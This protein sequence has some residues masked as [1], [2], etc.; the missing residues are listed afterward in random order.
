MFFFC[1]V[2]NFNIMNTLTPFVHA[3][4][5]VISTVHWTPTWTNGIF[6][7]HMWPFF[8]ICTES[9]SGEI[10]GRAQSLAHNGYPSIWWP[11]QI[12]SLP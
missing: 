7:M 6:N 10:L 3:G 1:I 11:E 8:T 12:C 2:S 4:I 5:F 9:D